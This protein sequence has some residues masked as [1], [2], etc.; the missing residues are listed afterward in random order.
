MIVLNDVSD[1]RIG[2]NSDDNAVTVITRDSDERLRIDS[3]SAISYAL[4]ER[5]AAAFDKRSTVRGAS[6]GAIDGAAG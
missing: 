6:S 5:I 3:K 2:F 4:I 1:K